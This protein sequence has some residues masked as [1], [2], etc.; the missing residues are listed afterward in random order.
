MSK[1]DSPSGALDSKW[2]LSQSSQ[3][4]LSIFKER[5]VSTLFQEGVSVMDTSFTNLPA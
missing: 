3:S 2:P 5:P 1:G 4:C